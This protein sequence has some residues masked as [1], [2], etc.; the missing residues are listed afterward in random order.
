MKTAA[1]RYLFITHVG[2]PGGAEFTMIPICKALGAQATVLL[3]EHGSMERILAAQGIEYRVR[4]L[5]R[6]AGAVRRGGGIGRLMRAIP[7]SLRMSWQL[8]REAR[9][10][11]VVVC[12]S[13]KAFVLASLAKPLARRPILW[14]MN[15]ILSAEHF[16]RLSMRVLVSLSKLSADHV[17]LCSHGSL[18]AWLAGGGRA[19]NVS[20]IYSGI[21]LEQISR[22]LSD[23]G[24]IAACRAR[25][26]GDAH[27]LVGMF[28]RLSAWKGQDVFLRALAQLPEVRGLIVGG[29]LSGD[30]DYES[31]LHALAR[32][33]GVEDRVSFLGHVDDPMTLMAACDIV[34]HCSTSPEPWGRVIVEAMFA[35]TPVIASNAGGVLEFVIPEETGQLTPLR[36]HAALAEAMRRYLAN[37]QWSRRIADTARARATAHYT[38]AATLSGFERAAATL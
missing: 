7:A 34:A 21:E 9:G 24:R 14:F 6:G 5:G 17:A 13:L 20:V 30:R 19:D 25:H 4:P 10:F 11:D 33:L 18:R 12:F 2:D 3:L 1:R 22:Q 31:G 27:A 23:A 36:D 37:P 15:D 32:E 16:S 38:S 35:G 8:A 29:A 28:G 26:R